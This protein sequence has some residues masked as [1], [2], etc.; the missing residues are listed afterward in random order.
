MNGNLPERQSDGDRRG[1]RMSKGRWLLV[2]IFV[3]FVAI[4]A[5]GQSQQVAKILES[6]TTRLVVRNL[7]TGHEGLC[8][9]FVRVIRTQWAYVGTARHCIEELT[10]V[11]LKA[12]MRLADLGLAMIVQ[13]PNGT[14][15]SMQ[16]R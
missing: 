5:S 12:N 16:Q 8:H 1:A 15:G 10:A 14:T 13:Y 9:G 2:L 3:G 6:V 7:F 4:P 11:P